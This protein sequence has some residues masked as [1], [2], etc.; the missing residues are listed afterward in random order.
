LATLV[1]DWMTRDPAVVRGNA[2]ILEAF[3]LMVDRGIRHLPV[4]GAGRLVGILSIDD[5]RGAFP[6][7]VSLKHE[8]GPVERYRLLDRTVDEA[9]TWLPQTVQA[10]APLAEAVGLFS[11]GRIGCL[12]VVDEAGRLLGMLSE[13]D[14]LRAL[15]AELR[16]EAAPVAPAAAAPGLVDELWGERKRLVREIER[17]Q[18]V[19]RELSADIRSEPRDSVDR[20]ID[21]HEVARLEPISERASR[22][23][24]AI[25]VALERAERGRF[26]ICERCQGRIPGARLRAIPEATLCVR[27]ARAEASERR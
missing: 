14:A 9:M 25:E 5:L 13:T 6:F 4:L 11:D 22:R 7:D 12:P 27:C 18:G 26:G 1:R 10:H 15:A 3:D 21:E 8:L 23:L 24:R 20:G 2:S 16:G 19:E 17:L